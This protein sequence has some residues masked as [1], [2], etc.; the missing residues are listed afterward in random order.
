M[1]LLDKLLHLMNLRGLDTTY[2]TRIDQAVDALIAAEKPVEKTSNKSAKV[3][4]SKKE[5][6]H[7]GI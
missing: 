7:I 1:T 3:D 4:T 2:T 5:E 6:D